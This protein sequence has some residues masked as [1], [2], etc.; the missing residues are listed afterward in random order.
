M[1]LATETV[2]AE[3]LGV[4]IADRALFKQWVDVLFEKTQQFSLIKSAEEQ[5][6]EIADDI[7]RIK[8]LRDYLAE[9]VTDRRRRP[10]EDLLTRLVEAEV[11]AGRLTDAEVF[12]FARFLLIAGHAVGGYGPSVCAWSEAAIDE[13]G[14]AVEQALQPELEQVL[15]IEIVIGSGDAFEDGEAARLHD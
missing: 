6:R 13:C 4:P 11:D 1:D 12:T 3:L 8:P 10:R 9:H 7:R 5:E 15:Q 14:E 2:I